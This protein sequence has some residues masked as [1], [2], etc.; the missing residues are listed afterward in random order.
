MGGIELQRTQRARRHFAAVVIEWI[1][2][3]CA[4]GAMG[5]RVA[6]RARRCVGGAICICASECDW[7]RCVVMAVIGLGGRSRVR[8]A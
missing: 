2:E 3:I 4:D 7:R 8:V 5:F 1:R 6:Q